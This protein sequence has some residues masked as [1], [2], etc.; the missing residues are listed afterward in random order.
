M[1]QVIP[2]ILPQ[3]KSCQCQLWDDNTEKRM[4]VPSALR[5]CHI[6]CLCIVRPKVSGWPDCRLNQ[7]ERHLCLIEVGQRRMRIPHTHPHAPA[8]LL[9]LLINIRSNQCA[10]LIQPGSETFAFAVLDFL[11]QSHL[12]RLRNNCLVHLFRWQSLLDIVVRV[13]EVQLLRLILQKLFHS[14]HVLNENLFWQNTV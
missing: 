3:W 14:L 13:N 8:P 11:S 2:A 5:Y 1:L 4:R 7:R 12:L 10:L 9:I 6:V